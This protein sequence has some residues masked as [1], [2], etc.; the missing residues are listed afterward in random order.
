MR[1]GPGDNRHIINIASLSA[2]TPVPGLAIYAAT[3]HAVL[4]FTGSLQGDLLDAGIPITVH[5]LCP[6]AADTQLLR[7]HD[8][9]PAAA[10]NWSGPR[11]LTPAGGGGARGCA[12]RLEDAR[13]GDPA[14]AR[15]GRARDG[16]ARAARASERGA[17]AQAGRPPPSE[18]DEWRNDVT[19]T[20]T[21]P[22]TGPNGAAAAGTIEVEN[23]S[24]GKVIASVPVVP[25]EQVAELVARARRRA[26][27]L[28]GARLRR[29]RR[30]AEA[31]PE[32]DLGQ[33]SARD[34][35]DRLRDRQGPRGRARGGGRLRGRR[36]RLL[37]QERRGLPRRGAREDG[38]AVRQGPQADRALRAGRRG[39]A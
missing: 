7:E 21:V 37:G 26:A 1:S 24:T 2:L 27:R 32:V 30:G 19:E 18:S 20:T 28:G 12:A 34:R 23:P 29:P 13:A 25:P 36:V 22:S 35:H 16:D 6:D 17:A 15:L 9:E 38:V 31:L 4:G 33:L 8:H 14:L 3:K 5:A 11:L 10:I 39:R